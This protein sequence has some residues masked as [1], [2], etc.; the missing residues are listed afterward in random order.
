MGDLERER[1]LNVTWLRDDGGGA[2]GRQPPWSLAGLWG[3]HWAEAG[4]YR[5][6][7]LLS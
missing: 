7:K 2:S 4:R 1:S 5:L 6:E 3:Y